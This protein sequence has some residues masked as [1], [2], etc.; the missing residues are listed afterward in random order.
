MPA[1]P[2]AINSYKRYQAGSW[3]P[4]RMAWAQ[5]NPEAIAAAMQRKMPKAAV[6]ILKPDNAGLKVSLKKG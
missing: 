6:H 4:T 3:A 2:A 1:K 5:D